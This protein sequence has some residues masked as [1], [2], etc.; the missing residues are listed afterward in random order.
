MVDG[1]M[2]RRFLKANHFSKGE[3]IK[4]KTSR[5]I[6]RARRSWWGRQNLKAWL[7][8]SFNYPVHLVSCDPGLW[9]VICSTKGS[10][11]SSWPTVWFRDAEWLPRV[12]S[13]FKNGPWQ[14]GLWVWRVVRRSPPAAVRFL[15]SR[16]KASLC[17]ISIVVRPLRVPPPSSSY[18]SQPSDTQGAAFGLPAIKARQPPRHHL[19]VGKNSQ[20]SS[21]GVCLI[22]L[23]WL[24]LG[25]L[26]K[27]PISPHCRFLLSP[28]EVRHPH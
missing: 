17:T 20:E 19:H 24:I 21:P 18:F 2:V 12:T 10:Y 15:E 16:Y 6:K 5:L 1:T 4:Q 22:I 11:G 26:R 9:E 13:P 23:D 27:V 25:W 3:K 8:P 28:L 14:W 7:I